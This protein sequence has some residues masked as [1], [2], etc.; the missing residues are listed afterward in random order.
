MKKYTGVKRITI[1]GL[2]LAGIGV[3]T[4]LFALTIIFATLLFTFD[5]TDTSL[6]STLA[7][8]TSTTYNKEIHTHILKSETRDRIAKEEKAR[9]E[10]LAKEK[11]LAESQKKDKKA[12][13]KKLATEKIKKDEEAEK[14]SNET[15]KNAS[16]YLSPVGLEQVT[17]ARFVDGDTTRFYY[18]GEDV[19][20]RYLLIDTPETMH[21]HDGKQPFGQEASERTRELL[22]NASIIEVEHDIGERTD[23]YNRHL[24]YIYADGV[25]VNEVL[26]REGLAQVTYIYP[27]NIRHLDRLKEAERL[28]KEEGLGIWSL[29]SPFDAPS[30]KESISN[31]SSNSQKQEYFQNCT[32]LRIVYPYGVPFDHPAYQS[33]MDGDKDGWAC[34]R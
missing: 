6:S 22:V 3:I 13:E 27:P 11:E 24:A 1:A 31:P 15:E 8:N 12:K 26:V 18:H 14:I 25:M 9:A 30:Y 23:K 7:T 10:K 16:K 33:K 19:S 29:D 5:D 32:E 20:F 28:A 2:L 4:Y 17:V 34:E 21:P